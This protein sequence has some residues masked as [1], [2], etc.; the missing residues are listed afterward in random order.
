MESTAAIL[1]DNLARVISVFKLSEMQ[2]AMTATAP[3]PSIRQTR[4]ALP[5][6][7]RAAGARIAINNNSTH[8]ALSGLKH[9]SAPDA[10]SKGDWEEF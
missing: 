1:A 4:S 9:V 10:L 7:R 6:T 8:P 3:H 2:T 5:A